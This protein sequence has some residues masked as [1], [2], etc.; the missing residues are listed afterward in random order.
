MEKDIGF[1]AEENE[2]VLV[3]CQR[4]E[5]LRLPYFLEYYRGLGIKSFIIIDN[6]STDGSLEYLMAQADVYCIQDRTRYSILE[7]CFRTNIA[8]K[9]LDNRWV[10]FADI[11]E[12]L[13]IPGDGAV[14]LPRLCEWWASNNWFTVSSPMVDMYAASPLAQ[15]H[16]EK[17]EPF[18]NA[19]PYFDARGYR[20][21]LNSS[22]DTSYIPNFRLY[23]GPRERFFAGKEARLSPFEQFLDDAYFSPHRPLKRRFL[24]SRVR[25]YLK[26]KHALG[27]ILMQKSPLLLW[28]KGMEISPGAHFL[29]LTNGYT[30]ANI[31][32]DW[33]PLLHFKYFQDF[34]RK[35]EV[36][37]ERKEH[38]DGASEYKLY[39][40]AMAQFLHL[41]PIYAHTAK[42]T[43]YASMLPSGLARCSAKTEG[44]VKRSLQQQGTA[45]VAA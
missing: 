26:E 17:G 7:K 44:F 11:D 38:W 2:V 14:S 28:K 6:G 31:A 36:E 25:C 5:L 29:M 41:N 12:L 23:G 9:Y 30:T 19:C 22:K 21:F 24:Q 13:A 10:L 34:K 42:Y 8:N 32:P 15:V 43:G 4:N 35:C 1:T 33:C 39:N 18:W 20:I 16:Y 3:A 40:N 45:K 27:T 37:V